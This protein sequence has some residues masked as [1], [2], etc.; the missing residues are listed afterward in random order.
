VSFIKRKID[1]QLALDGDTFD[2]SNNVVVL[3]GL[4]TLASIRSYTGSTGSFA[5]QLEITIFGMKNQDMAKLSTLGFSAGTYRKNLINVFAGDDD[6]GMSQVFSGGITYGNVDYNAM[7]DVGVTLIASALANSQYNAIAASS[8][9]G[10]M[11]VADMLEGIAKAANLNFLNA[12]VQAKLSNHAV[13]GTAIDQ[14]KDICRAANV[15]YAIQ[16]NTLVIWPAGAS[17]DS[18]VINIG[19]DTGMVGYPMYIINGVE[20][21]SEFNPEVEV[22]RT[23]NITSST[24]D[25]I[26]NGAPVPGANGQFYVWGVSH[27]LSSEV[28]NGPWFTRLQLGVSKY[29]ANAAS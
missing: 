8:Y 1:V 6:K 7:P 4:R 19:P 27:D 2:G 17:R 12:G 23:V 16:N 10:S 13:G 18:T 11:S 28:P 22:G 24:P 21:V 25:P 29:N 14:I 26:A 20:V 5:S 15:S 3:S 9:K